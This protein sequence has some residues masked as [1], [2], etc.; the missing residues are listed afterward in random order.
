MAAKDFPDPM[1]EAMSVSP[2]WHYHCPSFL[3]FVF[4]KKYVLESRSQGRTFGSSGFPATLVEKSYF[5]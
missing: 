3:L 2:L 5:L 1:P 4:G